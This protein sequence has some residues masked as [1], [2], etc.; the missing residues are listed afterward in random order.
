MV[1]FDLFIAA[2][3][4]SVGNGEANTK[5]GRHKRQPLITERYTVLLP[6]SCNPYSEGMT[7]HWNANISCLYSGNI[8]ALKKH[9]KHVFHYVLVSINT[10]AS[11]THFV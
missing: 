6:H 5:S 2:H 8:A 9:S 11:C 7:A 1:P 3:I 4:I 10:Y